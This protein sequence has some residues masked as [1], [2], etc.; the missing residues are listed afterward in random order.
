[1]LRIFQLKYY[2]TVNDRLW[3]G[4]RGDSRKGHN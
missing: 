3:P 2:D 1:M 4:K